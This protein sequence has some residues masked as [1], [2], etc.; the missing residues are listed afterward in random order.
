MLVLGLKKGDSIVIG[1]DILV[2]LVRV[3]GG[4]VRIGIEAPDGVE[5]MRDSLAAAAPIVARIDKH[6]KHRQ[7]R[8]A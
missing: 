1:Q 3:H 2:R 4:R 6:R 8:V 7:E 5:I